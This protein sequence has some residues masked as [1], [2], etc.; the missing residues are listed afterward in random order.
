[1]DGEYRENKSK[2]DGSQK[3]LQTKSMGWRPASNL[4][5]R[6]QRIRRIQYRLSQNAISAPDSE[7]D[8]REGSSEESGEEESR[9]IE[10][11]SLSNKEDKV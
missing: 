10:S 11:G 6:P 7:E 5:P 3:E 8:E 9:E 1:M 2:S 4:R